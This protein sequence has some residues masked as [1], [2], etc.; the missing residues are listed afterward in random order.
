[1]TFQDETDA[2]EFITRCCGPDNDGCN[3]PFPSDLSFI[4]V[5]TADDA[6]PM[7]LCVAAGVP[8][9]EVRDVKPYAFNTDA[10]NVGHSLVFGNIGAGKSVFYSTLWQSVAEQIIKR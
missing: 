3:Q 4:S 1:M 2:R 5:D 10:P 9:W 7:A 8:A 6:A